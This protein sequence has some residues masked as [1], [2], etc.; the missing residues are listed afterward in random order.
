MSLDLTVSGDHAAVTGLA[1]WLD[2]E[3]AEPLVTADLDMAY[4][5]GDS[6]QY[7]T[8]QSGDAFRG[9]A[10]EIRKRSSDLPGFV[11]DVAEVLRAYANRLERGQAD[12]D[13]YLAQ[14]STGGLTVVGNLVMPPTTTLQYCP[15]DN[16][17]AGDVKEYQRYLD[18]L[19]LYNDIAE[20]VGTWHGELEAWIAENLAPLTAEVEKFSSLSGLFTG[21]KVDNDDVV[22]LALEYASART[23]RD[24]RDY[25][26]AAQSMQADAEMF[27]D[28]LRSGNP[29]LRAAAEA[30]NPREMRAGLAAL[31]E[32]IGGVTKYSKLIPVVGGVIDVVSAGVEIADGG[33]AS[34]VGVGLLAGAGGGALAGTIIAGVAIPP[35]GVALIVGG[36]AAAAGAGGTWLWE[37]AVPLDVRE[38]IDDFFTGATPVLVSESTGSWAVGT[39]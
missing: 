6:Q 31:N 30:A 2:P 27:G 22:D 37:A 1:K 17:P 23:D 8:G 35:V 29:A 24:L 13:D 34:S 39:K 38:S 10:M 18:A 3:L 11:R 12:F 26:Q 16:A 7:W 20:H 32:A 21:L 5:W 19:E 14:A 9:A 15:A 4:T 33:S 28:H 25:R 36:A